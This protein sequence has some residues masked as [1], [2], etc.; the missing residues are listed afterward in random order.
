MPPLSSRKRS[1]RLRRFV[2][3][4]GRAGLVA[5]GAGVA[6]ALFTIA[7][8]RWVTPPTTAF[9]VQHRLSAW[10]TGPA[11]SPVRHR[12]V[13]WTDIN[14][15]LALAVVAAEDQRFPEHH[16]F[17]FEAIRDA[18]AERFN[19][20]PLRGA[21]TISQQV[22]KNLFLWPGR[23]FVR[24]GLEGSLTVMVEMVWSK[25]RILEVYL[26]VVEF[27]EG[28]YGVGA[29]S[30]TFFARPPSRIDREQAALLAAVLPAPSRLSVLAP[31]SYVRSRQNWIL[32]QMALLGGT[33]YLSGF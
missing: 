9:M 7:A 22:A 31:S 10:R 6:V 15:E 30:Q 18:L 4:L 33:S 13:D 27:G 19:G 20:G 28:V 24:K 12:W 2:R 29:A 14:P 25:R 5:I 23:S 17:D 1:L 8:L 16:G 3:R 26:N 32:K 21:S 11:I